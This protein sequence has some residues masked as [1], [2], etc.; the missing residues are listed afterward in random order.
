M[1]RQAEP[2]EEEEEEKD[3]ALR[4]A[5]KEGNMRRQLDDEEKKDKIP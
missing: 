2:E 5:P 1:Q 4:M 3:K